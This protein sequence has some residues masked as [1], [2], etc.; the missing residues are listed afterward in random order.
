MFQQAIVYIS[1]RAKLAMFIDGLDEFEG[2][3]Y[4][5]ISLVQSCVESPIKICVSSRPWVE[6]EGAFGDCPR[7]KMEDLTHQDIS[8][9][10][11]AKFEADTQFKSLQRRQ[12][13]VAK[14]LIESIVKKSSGVF[15]WVTIVVASLLAGIGAG[16]RVE[17][18]QKRLG[19]LPAEIKNLYERILENVDSGYREH[20]AQLLKLMAAFKSQPSP[21]LFWYADEV[22]FMNRAIKEDPNTVTRHEALER[23]EDIRRRLNSR[24]EGLLEIHKSITTTDQFSSRFEGTVDYLHKTVYEFVCSRRTQRRLRKYLKKPYDANLRIAAAYA[25]LA[26]GA[27]TWTRSTGTRDIVNLTG[28]AK[29][30]SFALSLINCLDHAS[31]VPPD[32]STEVVRLVDHLACVNRAIP[33]NIWLLVNDTTRPYMNRK[34]PTAYW[35]QNL[36]SLERTSRLRSSDKMLCLATSMSVVEYVRAR[37]K[38]GGCVIAQSVV[39]GP[40]RNGLAQLAERIFDKWFGFNKI[41]LLSLVRFSDP[42]SAQILK[43]LLDRGAKPNMKFSKL[44]GDLTTTRLTPWEEILAEAL[45]Y[46][47]AFEEENK[48]KDNVLR[49]VRRMVDGGA[50]VNLKT[51]KTARKHASVNINEEEAYRCLK[52]MKADPDAQFEVVVND[53]IHSITYSYFTPTTI[54][55]NTL[56]TTSIQ[57]GNTPRTVRV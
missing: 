12:A 24:C 45:R 48:H 25:A 6:F 44:G 1:S 33:H 22:D 19:L 31:N 47:V 32:S 4:A 20:T 52:R 27:M 38:P 53:D 10:V 14:E 23:V 15:L 55:S 30:N 17:D 43:H 39:P 21:L 56:S 40:R 46:C 35:A 54:S 8:D 18:L 5:L 50:K 42:E 2:N 51:V 57:N 37:A 9:Y 34:L 11:F 49:C 28:D 16:D 26:K 36:T 41:S 3:C 7:L 29:K 13:R